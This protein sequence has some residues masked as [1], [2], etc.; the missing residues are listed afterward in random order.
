MGEGHQYDFGRPSTRSAMCD[1]I[2]WAG[3][4]VGAGLL[5]AVMSGRRAQDHQL[6]RLELDPAFGERVLNALVLADRPNLGIATRE[7][8]IRPASSQSS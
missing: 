3:V 2:N 1:R 4:G 5:A 6:G 7:K 8:I